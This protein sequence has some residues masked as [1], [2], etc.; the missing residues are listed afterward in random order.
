VRDADV[1][2]VLGETD[3]E[4]KRANPSILPRI[5]GYTYLVVGRY[6]HLGGRFVTN[7]AGF[8]GSLCHG[9]KVV[10]ILKGQSHCER[11]SPSRTSSV[12][13]RFWIVAAR[14]LV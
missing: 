8:G 2:E 10:D 12:F 7:I 4:W 5:I 1:E 13:P 9:S 3:G 6:Q 14:L 11:R